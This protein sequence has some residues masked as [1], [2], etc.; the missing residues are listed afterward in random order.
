MTVEPAWLPPV[1]FR[2][3]IFI[4]WL[5]LRLRGEATGRSGG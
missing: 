1:R 4:S 5:E 3:S 2:Q